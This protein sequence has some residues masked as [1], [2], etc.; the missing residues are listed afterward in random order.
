[1]EERKFTDAELHDI[2]E[3]N[4]VYPDNYEE[5]D[6]NLKD[7]FIKLGVKID[8][9]GLF[10]DDLANNVVP[11][12]YWFKACD[13]VLDLAYALLRERGDDFHDLNSEIDDIEKSVKQ[14]KRIL[15]G[16]TS[17]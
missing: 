2:V 5:L 7:Y 10:S 13:L 8:K 9:H 14:L 3:T 16:R 11:E 15:N 17:N 6:K 1:M 4:L 12:E